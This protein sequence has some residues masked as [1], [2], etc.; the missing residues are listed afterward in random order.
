MMIENILF[1][2]FGL[3]KNMQTIHV[4]KSDKCNTIEQEYGDN[5]DL[6]GFGAMFVI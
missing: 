4:L 5:H 3:S 1:L 2:W 6:K